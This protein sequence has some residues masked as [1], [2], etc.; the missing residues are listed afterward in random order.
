MHP[1]IISICYSNW[2][3]SCS[4]NCPLMARGSEQFQEA[5][6]EK[7]GHTVVECETLNSTALT[8]DP[9]L[10]LRLRADG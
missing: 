5:P 7:V 6:S 8:T 2:H 9:G 3:P 1:H 10:G 4:E